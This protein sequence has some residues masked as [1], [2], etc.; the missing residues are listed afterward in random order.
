MSMSLAAKASLRQ[1]KPGQ[2]L[3]GRTSGGERGG[4]GLWKIGPKCCARCRAGCGISG[5]LRRR[6]KRPGEIKT[7]DKALTTLAQA[8][9]MS[10]GELEEIGLPDY[11]F[12]TEGRLEIPVGPATPCR[13]SKVSTPAPPNMKSSPGPPTRKSLP[14]PPD[15]RSRPAPRVS[16]TVRA[17]ARP[18]SRA[19]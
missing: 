13:S 3:R 9:G 12:D 17:R 2:L 16:S 4:A 15:R 5:R 11:G 19:A 18:E 8:R 6:L 14:A 7:V 1:R 10:A